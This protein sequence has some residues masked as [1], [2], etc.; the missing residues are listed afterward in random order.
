VDLPPKQFQPLL[1]GARSR[2]IPI[3]IV[4]VL[5]GIA[6]C[7]GFFVPV[8]QENNDCTSST[9]TGTTGSTSTTSTTAT[10][11]TT[12]TTATTGTTG[13]TST[14]ATTG[15]TSTTATTGTTGTTTST[16]STTG[17]PI[18]PS[19]SNSSFLY[20]SNASNGTIGTFAVASG[21]VSNVAQSTVK[22]PASPT[23][24]AATPG[25]KFLYLATSDGAVYLNTIARNGNLQA[26]NDGNPVANVTKPT[27]MS[28]DRAGKW[29][30]V[31]SSAAG[32]VQEFQIDAATGA[33]NSV[34]Q[35]LALDPGKPTEVYLTPD[36]QKLFVPLGKGGLDGFPFDPGTGAV[37]P[38]QHIAPLH[39]GN[40]ADNVLTSDSA[41]Q[42]L[43]VGEANT[44][45]RAF[46]IGSG[47]TL[48]EISGSPF[49]SPKNVPT[50]MVMDA[51]SGDLVAANSA[52]SVI[53]Q[54]S[55]AADGALKAVFR[56]ASSADSS[57]AALI[58]DKNGRNV[59]S[60]SKDAVPDLAHLP[61]Q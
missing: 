29:L 37:G 20:V 1:R 16:T 27:W 7:Q 54:Y 36:D 41:S 46:S 30:F 2:I 28:M 12:S 56:S 61:S 55:I 45:I 32:S 22:A 48:Q 19:A 3:C 33:L 10:T 13:T 5:L 11:G 8:C 24:I 15:T 14:T 57:P 51:S 53:T 58:P 52:A 42:N 59:L 6:G 21:K 40:S 18:T 49:G 38:R 26:G 25:G 43:Y 9:T 31:A 60:I 34:S 17:S 4:A 23:A 47:A 39:D 50:S 35:S 44:G